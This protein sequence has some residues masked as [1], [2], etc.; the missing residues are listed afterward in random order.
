MGESCPRC[1]RP[2]GDLV[3]RAAIITYRDTLTVPDLHLTN[4]FAYALLLP[5]NSK[6][7]VGSWCVRCMTNGSDAELAAW[8]AAFS[9][10][11]EDFIV[12]PNDE[13]AAA[14][15]ARFGSAETNKLV[16]VLRKHHA[17]H[18]AQKSEKV[19]RRRRRKIDMARRTLPVK[20]PSKAK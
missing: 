13:R 19:Q 10:I 6:D 2:L 5:T 16:G 18:F 14:Y 4:P 11:M 9:R 1:F 12:T 20:R 17:E 15:C 8:N 7:V 3:S